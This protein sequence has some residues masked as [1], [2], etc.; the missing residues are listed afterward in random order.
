MRFSL[1]VR[2][3]EAMTEKMKPEY[4]PSELSLKIVH[5]VK[6][7]L[8]MDIDELFRRRISP[9][10]MYAA[11]DNIIEQSDKSNE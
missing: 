4:Q 5:T 10:A 6:D 2:S 11:I 7:Y 8:S 1:Y 3:E 9:I